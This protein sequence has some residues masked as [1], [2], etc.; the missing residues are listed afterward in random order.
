MGERTA[1]EKATFGKVKTG[2]NG[3]PL[4]LN[5]SNIDWLIEQYKDESF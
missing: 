2:E 4:E 1:N 5:E 3:V